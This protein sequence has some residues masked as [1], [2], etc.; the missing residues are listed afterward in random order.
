MIAARFNK[1]GMDAL[2][3]QVAVSLMVRSPNSDKGTKSTRIDPQRQIL[4]K[5]ISFI[6]SIN[7]EEVIKDDIY[8]YE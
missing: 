1:L 2:G 6:S 5:K 3:C 7:K 8:Q 4:R